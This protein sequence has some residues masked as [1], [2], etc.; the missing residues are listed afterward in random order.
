MD[1]LL[2][3]CHRIP[4]PPDKG[5][6]IRSW[7]L[8]RHLCH[9]Y[10]IHLGAFVDDPHDRQHREAVGR[11]VNGTMHLP[12]LDRRVA[13]LRALEGLLRRQPLTVP[14]YRQAGMARWVD[15]VVRRHT[16]AR[17]VVFSSSM[18]PYVMQ[19]PGCLAGARLVVDLVDVDSQKWRQY[20]DTQR[21][22]PAW[23]H[24]R[25]A[26]YL[27]ELE[28]DIVRRAD[29]VT[30]VNPAELALLRGLMP[31][32]GA[33]LACWENG[34]DSDHF[35]PGQTLP[36][37]YG[38]IGGPVMVFTGAMDYWPNVDGLLW[39]ATSVWPEVRR[40]CPEARL[41]A[42]GGGASPG[43][44]RQAQALGV[45]LTG[46][47]VDVRPWLRHATAAVAPLRIAQGTQNKVL[48]A[49][50]M[51][52]PMVLTPKALEGVRP[53]PHWSRWVADDPAVLA[54]MS[55]QL[56]GGAGRDAGAAGRRCV[57]QHHD[58]EVNLRA[59]DAL[60]ENPV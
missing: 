26:R 30:V 60:L 43:F 22:L 45:Q 46:R 35:D 39:Y 54:D 52:L 57:Q 50:A 32:G 14:F 11:L 29:A 42:V 34:V 36:N 40:R 7:R 6:K 37:P 48:E 4:Y 21:G 16:P 33:Q 53:C 27:L 38:A 1:D 49:M 10:R 58:W 51:A 47:V 28:R 55:I 19:R 20:A 24:R 12:D 8:L 44:C 2:L 17:V 13:R 31:P 56:L 59:L 15:D 18:A 5:D 41:V 3:L 25:E 9:R 23:I